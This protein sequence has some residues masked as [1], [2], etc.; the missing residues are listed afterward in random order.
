MRASVV[1]SL[2]LVVVFST[3]TIAGVLTI[4]DFVR[5]TKC[6]DPQVSPDGGWVTFVASVPDLDKNGS[7]SDI[8]LVSIDG[9]KMKKLTN[10]DAADY[11]PRWS[12][13]GE[14]IA[15]VSTRSGRAQ[16]WLIDVNGGE[17]RRLTDISTGASDP[18]WSP[19]GRLIAFHSF[20]YPDCTDDSCNAARENARDENPVKARVADRLLYRHWNAW[21][22]GKRNHLFV[23]DVESGEVKD[24]T[25]MEDY[26]YPPFPWGG[27]G[28]YAFSPDGGK[29][30]CV[31]KRVD[32]EAVSTNTDLFL[33]D[34]SAG[35]REKIT[36]NEAADETPSFSP[37]GRYIAYRAQSVPGF[38]SDR[39]RLMLYD[40]KT[41]KTECLTE[42]FDR[43]VSEFDWARDGRRIYFS[44][45]D[46]GHKA[47]FSLDVRSGKIRKILARANNSSPFV[48]PDG[49]TIVFV[50]RSFDFPH[51]IWRVSTHGKGLRRLTYFNRSILSSLEINS[52][53]DVR[54]EG[55]EGATIQAF[56]IKPP[57]FD[58]G[59]KYPALVL[60]HGGPQS[61]FIDSWYTNWNAQVFASAG[62]VI[63]IPNFHGSDGFG[64]DFVNAISRDWGGRCY[65]DIMKGVDYLVSLPFVDPDRIGAAGASYG[66]YMIDW[67]EGHTD[68]F[69]CLISMAGP[70]NLTSEYGTTEELWFPEW[71]F[72][73]TPYENPE[74]YEKWS[75]HRFARNFRTP[76]MVLVGELDYRVPFSEGLQMFTALQ[77]QGVPSRLVYFPD[78]GHWILKPQNLRFYYEQFIGWMD[79]YL[80]N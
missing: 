56:I 15:F 64:Q 66:G 41:G 20:V 25:P 30:C 32:N 39:W 53:E 22:E 4:D 80:K 13:D 12:P 70:Y 51:S 76:C 42:K 18:I 40:T 59:K 44:A 62:Y 31:C 68:R 26:D 79:K 16:V 9:K 6:S 78:E 14:R 46:D 48:T 65:E 52:A 35:T 55:A 10:S 37:D 45:V 28:D 5:M 67:I 24:I 21:K 8:W 74:L 3:A 61:A 27:S 7:N 71:E 17:A 11:H 50:R 34:L 19:D 47:L 29:I 69:A 77:R 43:W 1:F 54:Y 57:H 63:F 23:I 73:G 38:E 33:I 2:L 49:K 72:G 75:P 58:P 36:D 60:V